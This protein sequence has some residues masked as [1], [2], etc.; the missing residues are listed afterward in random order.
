[1]NHK[2]L[3]TLLSVLSLLPLLAYPA[4]LVANAMQAAAYRD[5][6]KPQSRWQKL[7]MNGFLIGTT[8]YPL[9]VF[10]S[11]ALANRAKARLDENRALVWSATP[12]GFLFSMAG[13]FHLLLRIEKRDS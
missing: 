4:V 13:L 8:A 1:M 10:A 5:P 2:S 11:V 6:D 7:G 3:S 12:L 9:V